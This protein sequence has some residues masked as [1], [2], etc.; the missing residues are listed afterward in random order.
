MTGSILKNAI[1]FFVKFA[2]EDSVR[3]D[4]LY[5]QNNTLMPAKVRG[6]FLDPQAGINIK[7]FRTRV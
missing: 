1:Y 6:L 4:D 7:G 2:F 3:A 5:K